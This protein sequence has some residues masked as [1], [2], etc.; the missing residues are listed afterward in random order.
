MENFD[1]FKSQGR[2]FH[3]A[4]SGVCFTDIPP[5]FRGTGVVLVREC[6]CL[7]RYPGIVVLLELHLGKSQIE[8]GLDAL[9]GGRVGRY[10]L[11][12]LL[13]R[14]IVQPVV[15]EVDRQLEIGVFLCVLGPEEAGKRDKEN[16]KDHNCAD[17]GEFHPLRFFLSP[18]RG[19]IVP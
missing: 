17:A 16:Q 11:L 4:K 14:K 3:I 15:E 18:V 10:E 13:Q 1:A 2:L 9:R 8:A 6:K 5:R 12:Q 7:E 19:F